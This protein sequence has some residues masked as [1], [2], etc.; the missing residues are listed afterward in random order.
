MSSNKKAEKPHLQ[1]ADLS[2]N[3]LHGFMRRNPELT[4]RI[5][6]CLTGGRTT[7]TDEAIR[8]WFADIEAYVVN[9]EK[10]RDVFQDPGRIFNFDESY[11]LLA[12]KEGYSF[13]AC[14][15]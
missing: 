15:L 5:P 1:M 6:E 9:E 10:V 2:F 4:E 12:K 13:G 8:K 11:F 3:W 14:R 7:V